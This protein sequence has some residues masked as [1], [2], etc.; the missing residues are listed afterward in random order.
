MFVDPETCDALP[1]ITIVVEPVTLPLYT[2][3]VVGIVTKTPPFNIK[4]KSK[5]TTVSTGN[6]KL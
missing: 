1:G 5:F 6:G 3:I 4:F 2:V